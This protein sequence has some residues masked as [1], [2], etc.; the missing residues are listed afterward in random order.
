[1][2]YIIYLYHNHNQLQSFGKNNHP[3]QNDN[4]ETTGWISNIQS[5]FAIVKCQRIGRIGIKLF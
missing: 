4:N 3:S 5:S 2:Y 1:L